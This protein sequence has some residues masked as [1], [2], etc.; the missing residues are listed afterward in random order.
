MDHSNKRAFFFLAQTASIDFERKLFNFKSIPGSYNGLIIPTKDCSLW[1]KIIKQMYS[2][3]Q[4]TF[5]L[6]FFWDD[7][8]DKCIFDGQKNEY[9]RRALL[10][11]MNKI[12]ML[13]NWKECTPSPYYQKTIDYFKITY[14]AKTIYGI[15]VGKPMKSGLS[16][17]EP[18]KWNMNYCST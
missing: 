13:V 4:G 1:W 8:D 12:E 18:L 6:W 14:D 16:E 10:P 5:G 15:I 17:F 3:R 11:N 9:Y 7:Q 2:L